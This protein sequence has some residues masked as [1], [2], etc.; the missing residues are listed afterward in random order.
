MRRIALIFILT[1]FSSSILV[2]AQKPAD[3]PTGKKF[4]IQSAINYGKNNGGYWDIPG[5]P[6]TIQKGS[7]VQVYNFD[8]NHDRTYSMHFKDSDGYYE[9][10]VGNTTNARIDIQGGGKRNGTSVKTWTRHRG[11]N[12]KFLFRHLGNG[13][14]K[15]YD[16]NS[17]KAICLAARSSA[18][19]S[20]V[21]IW[22]DH[23][24][25]WMEW[26]LI[27]AQTRRAFVPGREATT[28]TSTATT[29]SG[30]IA[31]LAPDEEF[32]YGKIGLNDKGSVRYTFAMTR[33][34]NQDKE[35]YKREMDM[36]YGPQPIMGGGQMKVEKNPKDYD[37][38]DYSV[39]FN[40]NKIGTY[41]RIYDIPQ[42]DGDID[43]WITPDGQHISFAGVKGQK[44]YPIVGNKETW[45]YF[46]SV[47]Q[48]PSFDPT[49]SRNSFAMEWGPD[50]ARLVEDGSFKLKGWKVIT[51][52]KYAY[53][54]KDLLY[55]G[56]Q[57]N[58]SERHVYLNH[59]PIAGPYNLVTQIGFLP[60][61]NKPYY[62]AFK[63][64]T[65]DNTSK[66][67]R[68]VLIGDREFNF[69]TD[70]HIGNLMIMN[71]W[72]CFTVKV[73]NTDYDG[74]DRFKKHSV[75]IWK[76]NHRTDEL[77]KYGNYAYDARVH[78]TGNTFYITTYD[79]KGSSILL[80][81]DGKML[82]KITPEKKGKGTAAFRVS[83]NGD[84]FTFFSKGMKKPYTLKKN[85]EVFKID[86]VDKIMGIETL[87]FCPKTGKVNLVVAKDQSVGSMDRTVINGNY[88][89][90]IKGRAHGSWMHFAQEGN[91]VISIYEFKR[92]NE[93]HFTN[94]IYRNGQPAS[95]LLFRS[96]LELCISPDASRYAALVTEADCETAAGEYFTENQY[97]DLK[98]KLMVD[99][100]IIEGNFGAPV[101]SKEK[102]KFVVLKQE[103]KSV[104]L[105]EL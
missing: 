105:V 3:I 10:K 57:E 97:M 76:Y 43:N 104:R 96:V 14:F 78:K 26:Y 55:V 74:D 19:R 69:S 28:S 61:T 68:S 66:A 94:Q 5:Y 44:Y 13:R 91:D 64:V 92:E 88:R 53:N 63:R 79:T 102:N 33:K 39:I 80:S 41:D 99:G 16:K 82:D 25:P 2:K 31:S 17:G 85:G 29:N 34:P 103:G 73:N 23:N 71:P 101:W 100:K 95:D 37:M 89:F 15:I 86:G 35:L 51:D 48:A 45:V 54:N 49:S 7:N 6:K 81:S 70:Q 32:I 1:F 93:K 18:N 30:S 77:I 8:D 36:P 98:R 9:I 21:H 65:V 27:D 38:Y 67:K 20:N 50:D 12:Q 42:D 22:D 62:N 60:G 47:I 90:D 46:W 83:P 24:G 72:V 11:N 56:A 75:E 59:K 40:G 58:K 87:K 84:F 52:V 4:F